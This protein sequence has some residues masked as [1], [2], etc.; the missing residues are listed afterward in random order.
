[1]RRRVYIATGTALSMLVSAVVVVSPGCAMNGEFLGLEDFQRD[2]LIGGLAAVLLNQLATDGGGDGSGAPV[3]RDGADGLNC[4]DLNGDAVED[5]AEDVNGDGRWDARDCRS[6]DGD[7]G[8]DG[9][10]GQ[11]GLACWDLDGDG[12]GDTGEDRNADGLWDADDCLGADGADG[13]NGPTGP[14]GPAGPSGPDAPNLFDIFVDDFFGLAD[15]V[16]AGG[17]NDQLV[18]NAVLIDEPVLRFEG[19]SPIGFRVAVPPTYTPGHDVTLRLF[20]YRTGFDDEADCFVLT[21]DP[22]RLRV[23]EGIEVYG[24][25]CAGEPDPACGRRWIRLD[26]DADFGVVAGLENDTLIVVDLPLNSAEGLDLERD[27]DEADRLAGGQFLA[28]EINKGVD[29]RDSRHYQ[30]LG[31]E[32]FESPAGTAEAAGGTV[33]FDVDVD[34]CAITDCNKNGVP[35]HDEIAACAP[36][37][38]AC[39][40][41]NKNRLPDVCELAA[42]DCDENGVLDECQENVCDE[43]DPCTRDFCDGGC[44]HEPLCDPDRICLD[45]R[46]VACLRDEDCPEGK[47]CVDGECHY[48]E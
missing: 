15:G 24:D 6:L 8:P 31:V 28:F 39:R 25:D 21:L 3:G 33:F 47:V 16:A 2:I 38:P 22:R 4:W 44:F 36:E 5:P 26:A 23:G 10:D 9:T 14:T 42:G 46:C 7:T 1:M 43:G 37:D 32:F 27:L 40:D 12:V 48:R 41:C 35:D 29:S 13:A 20:L 18:V 30:L 45:G 17:V 34:P 19:E 11:D